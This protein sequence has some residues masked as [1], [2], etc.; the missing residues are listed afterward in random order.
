MSEFPPDLPPHLYGQWRA[1]Q[2]RKK[3]Q[4]LADNAASVGDHSE[5][6]QHLRR[7]KVGLDGTESPQERAALLAGRPTIV[8]SDFGRASRWSRAAGPSTPTG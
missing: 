2:T 6:S 4:A 3:Y 7:T 8:G 1:E 5:I